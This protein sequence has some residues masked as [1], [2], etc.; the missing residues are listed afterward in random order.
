MGSTYSPLGKATFSTSSAYNDTV[1]L[2]DGHDVT[3]RKGT[4]A[5]GTGILKRGQICKIVPATGVITIGATAAEANCVLVDDTD[6]TSATV[7]AGVYLTGRMKADAIRWPGVLSHA[8]VTEAIRDVGIYIESVV[9]FDGTLVRNVP[10]EAETAE[11][12]KRLDAAREALKKAQKAEEEDK[13][14]QPPS[15]SLLPYLTE[16]EREKHIELA[17]IQSVPPEAKGTEP[18]HK[19]G[20]ADSSKPRTPPP[21]APGRK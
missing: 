1:L 5:S 11:A 2:A 10:T 6:A 9:G 3:S 7:E 17:S 21:S 19:S 12:R 16:E 13:D 18:E 20:E 15:D 8:D 4:V 14:K